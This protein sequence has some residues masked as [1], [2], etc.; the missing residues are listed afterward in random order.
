[1]RDEFL[2]DEDLDLKNLSPQELEL[3]WTAWLRAAQMNN[4]RDIHEY[5]HG[6]PGQTS[7]IYFLKSR[8]QV[9]DSCGRSVSR[10]SFSPSLATF[11]GR[12]SYKTLRRR[13]EY[14]RSLLSR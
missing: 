13:D 1:M 9:A 3:V 2:S 14:D 10:R 7:R 11:P 5:S 8:L 12:V 4:D 6:V